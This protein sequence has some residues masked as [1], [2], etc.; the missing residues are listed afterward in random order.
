MSYRIVKYDPVY[1]DQICELEKDLWSRDYRINE[2][3]LRWKYLESPY[4]YPPKLYLALDDEKP[5][6]VR[7]FYEWPFGRNGDSFPALCS[8]DLVIHPEYRSK[9]LYPE[10]MNFIM[11]DL[12]DQGYTYL[13]SFSAGPTALINSLALGWKV[14]GRMKSI[15]TQFYMRPLTKKLMDPVTVNKLIKRVVT[16]K[17]LRRSMN[18]PKIREELRKSTNNLPANIKFSY[19]PKPREMTRL[20]SEL[21]TNDKIALVRDEKYFKW[22]YRN[23]LSD[24]FFLYWQ[25]CELRGY[26]VAQ[27]PLFMPGSMGNFNVLELEGENPEIKQE[28]MKALLSLLDYRST[29]VWSGMLDENVRQ[30]LMASGFKE[31]GPAKSVA[32]FGETVLISTTGKDNDKIEFRGIDLLDI[33]NWDFKM[34]YSDFY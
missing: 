7:G 11:S 20:L 33:D 4:S 27:T 1:N 14:I 2:S 31:R 30:Y 6:G 21:D 16:T 32:E 15:H 18:P 5:I 10:L 19:E 12:H 34:T 29:T 13:L 28:L 8:A 25:D 9:G 26:L 24:Y 17:I 3:Y 23:P 22:R